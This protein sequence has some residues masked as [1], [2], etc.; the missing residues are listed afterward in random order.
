MSEA[1]ARLDIDLVDDFTPTLRRLLADLGA[2]E[3]VVSDPVV[4]AAEAAV[5]ALCGIAGPGVV[6]EMVL[7]LMPPSA[8]PFERGL[9]VGMALILGLPAQPWGV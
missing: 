1:S 3:Q 4:I 6:S 8:T 5:G 9:A 2:A 7:R